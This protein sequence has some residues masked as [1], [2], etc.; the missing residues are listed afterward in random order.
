V[1]AAGH[2]AINSFKEPMMIIT[3]QRDDR[4]TAT[5]VQQ[6]PSAPV[7]GL[8]PRRKNI[9]IP[10]SIARLITRAERLKAHRRGIHLT[11]LADSILMARHRQRNPPLLRIRLYRESRVFIS[12]SLSLS[13]PSSLYPRLSH[14]HGTRRYSNYARL[15]SSSPVLTTA[16]MLAR[17]L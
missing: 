13:P 3:L 10:R 6:F 17:A 8:L 1:H 16:R 14:V 7:I 4:A 12:L 2:A 5:A 9:S 15:Q 11:L